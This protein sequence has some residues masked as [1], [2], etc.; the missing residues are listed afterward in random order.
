VLKPSGVPAG[1]SVYANPDDSA[2]RTS[3]M[4]LNKTASPA[5]LAVVDFLPAQ[6]LAFE[7]PPIL[8]TPR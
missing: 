1:F 2:G 4:V 3:V 7:D 6:E 5:R 8:W